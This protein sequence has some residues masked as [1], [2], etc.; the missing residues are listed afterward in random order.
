MCFFYAS[1]WV[2]CFFFLSRFLFLP[3]R[4]FLSLI[5]SRFSHFQL[6]GT[7]GSS[8]TPLK[9]FRCTCDCSC[10][11]KLRLPFYTMKLEKKHR[12]RYQFTIDSARCTYIRFIL[13]VHLLHHLHLLFAF[14]CVLHAFQCGRVIF[15]F[16]FFSVLSYFDFIDILFSTVFDDSLWEKKQRLDSKQQLD[17]DYPNWRRLTWNAFNSFGANRVT[18]IPG[19]PAR[20]VRP[21]RWMYVLTWRGAS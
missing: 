5:R 9:S 17:S 3:F 6:S 19:L 14:Q 2:F 11:M 8:L 7:L 15:G 20:A 1:G 12:I 13:F 10:S 4:S 21:T 18:A 16:E